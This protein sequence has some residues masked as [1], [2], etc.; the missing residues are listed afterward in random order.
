M[1]ALRG[2]GPLAGKGLVVGL[3]VGLAAIGQD[4]AEIVRDD[5]RWPSEAE[6]PRAEQGPISLS[7]APDRLG[8]F[9]VGLRRPSGL[10]ETFLVA[11]LIVVY[12]CC[13]WREDRST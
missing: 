7:I 5:R 3:A 2:M 13:I 12:S 10:K 9:Y 8:I 1:A 4:E 6:W 11:C